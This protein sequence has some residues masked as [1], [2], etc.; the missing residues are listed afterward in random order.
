MAPAVL[1]IIGLLIGGYL[2]LNLGGDAVNTSATPGVQR[3]AQAIASAEGFYTAGSR[4][5]RNNNPGDVTQD[6][7]HKAVGMD[8][9]FPVY[10]TA[11]DGW[12]NLYAQVNLWLSGGSAHAT[13]DSTISDVSQFYTTDVPAG[14]QQTW[15]LNV[16]NGLGVT[17][18]TP[19]GTFA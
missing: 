11:A 6:L 8:G 12:A 3:L 7:I 1:M 10:A 17:V 9:A 5:Q 4:P 18:D 19:I 2:L 14:A 13:P 15:A 16:A